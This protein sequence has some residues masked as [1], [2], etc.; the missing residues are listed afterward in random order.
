MK[1]RIL[2]IV[3]SIFC[4][5]L[6]S[7]MVFSAPPASL[8]NPLETND[9]WC[10]P[11]DTNCNVDISV[12]NT[13][14]Q[15]LTLSGSTLSIEDGNNVLLSSI[16]TAWANITGIPSDIADGDDDTQLTEAPD[17]NSVLLSS[18]ATAWANITG[19]PSDIA[20][21]DDDTQLTEARFL[22]YKS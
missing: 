9:P 17:G 21:G 19:I 11:T 7:Q 13:D 15:S 6:V 16:A 10:G 8:Y 3:F 2:Y 4:L 18:I 22:R 12:I 1:T 20:D 5:A 14:D